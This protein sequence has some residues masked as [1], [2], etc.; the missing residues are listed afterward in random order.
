MLV[1][2]GGEEQAEKKETPVGQGASGNIFML[3]KKKK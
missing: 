1:G 2:S 3:N